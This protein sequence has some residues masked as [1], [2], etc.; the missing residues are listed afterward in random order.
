VLKI[1]AEIKSRRESSG[2]DF[3]IRKLTP[4]AILMADGFQQIV[5]DTVERDNVVEQ[6]LLQCLKWSSTRGDFV[7]FKEL[8]KLLD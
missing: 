8:Y 1:P 6:N 2:D 5:R 7:F 3:G 4:L